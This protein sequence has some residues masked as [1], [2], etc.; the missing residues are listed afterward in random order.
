MSELTDTLAMLA[1][2]S[3]SAAER[4]KA[5][6]YAG[7]GKS[8]PLYKNGEH[9]KAAW[10]LAGH[11]E[12]PGAVRAKIRAFAREHGLEGHLPDSAKTDASNKVMKAVAIAV[13]AKAKN[14]D[15]QA[16]FNLA[17]HHEEME[18]D[19]YQQGRL[20]HFAK[21]HGLLHHLPA[22]AHD[23]LHRENI[24]HEHDGIT[25]D[26]NGMHE[27][28]IARDMVHKAFTS[29]DVVTKAWNNDGQLIVEGWVSTPDKDLQNEV[30]L[31]EAFLD[32]CDDYASRGMPLSSEHNTKKYPV[33][34]GQRVAVVKGGK[35]LKSVAHPSDPAEFEHFPASGDGVYGRFAIT[36]P[37]AAGAVYKGNVRSF[38][39]IALPVETEPLPAGGRVLKRFQPWLESTI[40]AYPVN[41]KAV[42]TA[43]A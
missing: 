42:M 3:L 43:A 2:K 21:Q 17:Y 39:Y 25:N 10:D 16:L 1:Y 13:V 40:A 20:A 12:N 41:G 14:E 34:H 37:E 19:H 29:L 23:T 27:H 9:L 18:G 30:T 15:I 4:D 35:V 26:E 7:P 38:S 8:F 33:G 5:D 36:E 24:V 28:P 11:A 22:S 6:A 31:P 32:A